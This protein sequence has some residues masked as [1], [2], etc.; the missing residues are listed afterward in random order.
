MEEQVIN[1]ILL[2]SAEY[3]AIGVAVSVLTTAHNRTTSL[4]MP[5]SRRRRRHIAVFSS[6]GTATV[7]KRSK[8]NWAATTTSLIT[9]LTAIGALVF[10]GCSLSAARDQVAITEQGQLTDRYSRAIE[11]LG[12]QGEE[13][14]QVR[15]GGIYALERLARDS[16]RDQPT[17]IEVLATFVR[18]NVARASIRRTSIYER[19]TTCPDH[20]WTTP[21]ADVQAAL[22]VIG[23][24]NHT[25]DN[26]TDIVLAQACLTRV[27]LRNATLKNADLRDAVFAA[28]DMVSMDLSGADLRNV[29]LRSADLRGADLRNVDLRDSELGDANLRGANLTGADLS[30]ANLEHADLTGTNLTGVE[31]DRK[32]NTEGAVVDGRT[33]GAWW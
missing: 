15:L 27:S 18:S 12:D 5:A 10:T 29:D 17:I 13:R 2:K 28:S 24:R 8:S 25:N 1:S 20:A 22:T 14:L 6:P 3:L 11:Q 31:H 7:T 30:K 23:R 16:P 9:A 32:T 21:P 4:P 19:V 26:G 33:V